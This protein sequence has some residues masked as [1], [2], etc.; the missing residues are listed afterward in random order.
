VSAWLILACMIATFASAAVATKWVSPLTQPRRFVAALAAG[1]LA[2][3]IL[4]LEGAA[5]IP[6]WTDPLSLATA[7]PKMVNNVIGH[8]P[9]GLILVII[10]GWPYF[11]I[12][13]GLFTGYHQLRLYRKFRSTHRASNFS[14][15][16]H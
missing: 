15:S 13:W 12:V 11:L 2:S 5:M 6:G 4:V 9:D 10:E 8:G 16:P 3:L 14:S 1:F 7:D